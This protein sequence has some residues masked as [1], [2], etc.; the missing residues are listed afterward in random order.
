M[1]DAMALTFFYFRNRKRLW[2]ERKSFHALP[3]A[4]PEQSLSPNVRCTDYSRSS[5]PFATQFSGAPIH[6][7]CYA[8]SFF[9][10]CRFLRATS[11]VPSAVRMG[12]HPS[13]LAAVDD[14][15][16]IADGTIAEPAL[17]D[18]AHPGGVA[19]LCR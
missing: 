9:E 18:F 4:E 15:V 14:Q 19:R 16:L 1:F 6:R 11:G 7:A 8:L 5:G 13:Q 17:Q 2:A 10:P 3:F 12:T